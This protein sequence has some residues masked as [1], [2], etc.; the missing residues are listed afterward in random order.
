MKLYKLT[1][2]NG[3]TYG[4]TQWGENITHTANGNATKPLCSDAWIHAYEN[5]YVATFMNPIHASFEDPICWEAK[6]EIKIRDSVLKCGCRSLTTLRRIDLPVIS[7]EQRI[8]IA[9]EIARR[10]YKRSDFQQWA[11]NWIIKKD[12]TESAAYDAYN[13]AA[14]AA[15]ANDADYTAYN[16]DSTASTASAAA[17]I[18]IIGIIMEVLKSYE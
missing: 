16:A 14:A 12:R 5:I 7:I 11:E 8:H 13:A 4:G 18:D 15:D 6:G 1:D 10:L 3:M 2:E 17:T 9:I